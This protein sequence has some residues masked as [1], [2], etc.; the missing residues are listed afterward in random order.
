MDQLLDL[1]D[2]YV[3]NSLRE[4]IGLP[5]KCKVVVQGFGNVGLNA[6]QIFTENGHTIIAIS[7]SKGGIYNENGLDLEKLIEH[8]KKT[9]SLANFEESKNLTNQELLET[10]CNLLIPAAFENQI[11]NTNADKIRAKAILELANGP[12]TPEADEILFKKGIPVVPD[13]LANSGGVTVSYFEWDQ[14][15]KTNTGVKKKYSTNSCQ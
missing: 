5:E 14:N 9:G 15:L 12:I 1:A 7:D 3:F 8:K 13:I 2:F 10:E 6:A 4:Q 11:T